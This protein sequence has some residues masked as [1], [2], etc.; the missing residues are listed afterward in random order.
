LAGLHWLLACS[1]GSSSKGSIRGDINVLVVGDP[2]VS[3]SQLLGFVHHVREGNT[4]RLQA[5]G[6]R[7]I[8][9]PLLT[10]PA[11]RLMV[12]ATAKRSNDR[13]NHS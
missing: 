12:A 5:A 3:K 8:L 6:N 2:S 13:Q 11:V 10:Q 7:P 1:S 9:S 4:G